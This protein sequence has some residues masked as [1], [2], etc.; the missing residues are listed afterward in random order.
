M[1]SLLL[2]ALSLA[3]LHRL[4]FQKQSSELEPV[5]PVIGEMAYW[6][7][8]GT[9]KARVLKYE[10]NGPLILEGPQSDKIVEGILITQV[11]V[12][13]CGVVKFQE[14]DLGA[15]HG[16]A[17]PVEGAQHAGCPIKNWEGV[18]RIGRLK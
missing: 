3:T 11:D 4:V 7:E 2:V 18:W 10:A 14:N 6:K 1:I 5:G 8:G 9:W 12:P 16:T 13:Q 17:V 15:L